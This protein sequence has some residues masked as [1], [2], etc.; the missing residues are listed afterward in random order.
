MTNFLHSCIKFNT[1]LFF[2]SIFFSPFFSCSNVKNVRSFNDKRIL[3]KAISEKKTT[4]FQHSLLENSEQY[5]EATK[6]IESKS[7]FPK[8]LVDTNETVDS[9]KNQILSLQDEIREIRQEI[10][11]LTETISNLKVELH[12]YSRFNVI[13]E[14]DS[15]KDFS[16]ASEIA[17]IQSTEKRSSIKNSS[18]ISHPKKKKADLMGKSTGRREKGSSK[19]L[20]QI[21]DNEFI[22]K[23][24]KILNNIKNKKFTE[25]LS[26]LQNLRSQTN[27]IYQNSVI[28]YWIGEVYYLSKDYEKAL[29]YFQRSSEVKISPKNDKAHLMVAECLSRLGRT[30]EAKDAYQRFIENYPFSEFISRAKKMIQQL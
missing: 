4:S 15:R 26:E 2:A 17:G 14:V 11:N 13:D 22:S 24:E 23:L 27:D 28:D 16:Y 5:P 1:W 20:N 10:Q 3:Q 30:K 18:K 6:I 8:Y 19:K 12:N 9:Q 29:K 7:N 25:S 21:E